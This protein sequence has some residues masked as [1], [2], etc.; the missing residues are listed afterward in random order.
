VLYLP[1]GW[2][3]R[4]E[5]Q[6]EPSLHI[7]L[8]I[9]SLRWGDL[10]LRAAQQAVNA[11]T[12]LQRAIPLHHDI[13]RE[14]LNAEVRSLVENLTVPADCDPYQSLMTEVLQSR[15]TSL[16]G[17]TRSM[18]AGST[19]LSSD[20]RLSRRP[21]L[22]PLITS[23]DE[24]VTIRFAGNGVTAPHRFVPALDLVT[25]RETV[26][27]AELTAVAGEDATQLARALVANGLLMVC[28]VPS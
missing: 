22:R 20:T 12:S 11:D 21:G 27:V 8:G 1:R 5:S 24:A 16:A 19:Q 23:E 7:T 14:A 17:Q 13:P 26:T 6:C 25:A 3:H 2:A 10:V 28:S 4:V 18:V 15:P 9:R